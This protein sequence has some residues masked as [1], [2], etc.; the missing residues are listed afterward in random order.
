[1]PI[2]YTSTQGISTPDPKP[3]LPPNRDP[4]KIVFVVDG[5]TYTTSATTLFIAIMFSFLSM[6]GLMSVVLGPRGPVVPDADD[7]AEAELKDR[8][9]ACA[10]AYFEENKCVLK[11]GGCMYFSSDNNIA[12]AGVEVCRT[13]HPER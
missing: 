4:M 7:L 13:L 12:E 1:M 5:K 3:Q 9:E 6:G 10:R 2:P 11:K 8:R